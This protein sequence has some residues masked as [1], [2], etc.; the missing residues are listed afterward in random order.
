MKEG[1]Y[2]IS[3]GKKIPY[4]FRYEVRIETVKNPMYGKSR[5]IG[6]AYESLE[7]AIENAKR[8]AISKRTDDV[9]VVAKRYASQRNLERDFCMDTRME[10]NSWISDDY[11]K[12]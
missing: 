4:I 12:F 9:Y 10:W 3:N 8:Y 5:R 2:Y 1:T 11:P 6:S 7:E